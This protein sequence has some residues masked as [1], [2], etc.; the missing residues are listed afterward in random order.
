MQPGPRVKSLVHCVRETFSLGSEKTLPAFN[1]ESDRT[2]FACHT[3]SR[4]NE[5]NLA[6][7]SPGKWQ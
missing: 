2:R 6:V 5:L 1:E 4:S 3:C 7:V